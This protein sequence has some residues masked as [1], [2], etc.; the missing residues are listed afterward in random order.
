MTDSSI[1]FWHFALLVEIL[2]EDEDDVA[3]EHLSVGKHLANLS[4]MGVEGVG[5]LQVV[6]FGKQAVE[7]GEYVSAE[8]SVHY[9]INL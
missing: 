4:K 2:V 3:L 5:L 9:F 7:G 8:V 6:Y 1:F